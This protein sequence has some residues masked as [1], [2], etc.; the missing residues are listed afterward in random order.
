MF[1]DVSGSA[2]VFE[3]KQDRFGGVII[4]VPS[5]L[6]S[7]SQQFESMLTSS[8]DSWKA[9]KKRGV[10]LKIPSE[11]VDLLPFCLKQMGFEIH[12]ARAEYV[13]LTK[14]LPDDEP[15]VL[16]AIGS[17]SMGVGC[18]VF[19]SKRQVRCTDVPSRQ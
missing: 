19:N 18:C 11:R 7:E 13:M 9:D 4:D 15:N 3:H 17:T 1:E 5:A 12:H 6:P 10:W 16:P 2:S 14:W 8:V